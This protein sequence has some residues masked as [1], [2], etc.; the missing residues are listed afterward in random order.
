MTS[1]V[2]S[3]PGHDQTTSRVPWYLARAVYQHLSSLNK[4]VGHCP[5]TLRELYQAVHITFHTHFFDTAVYE[6][7]TMVSQFLSSPVSATNRLPQGVQVKPRSARCHF[8]LTIPFARKSEP[9]LFERILKTILFFYLL[10]FALL[11]FRIQVHVRPV[12][13]DLK[14]DQSSGCPFNP[15]KSKSRH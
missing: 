3:Q 6:S 7:A 4:M 5:D 2:H 8:S 15:S 9:R 1:E 11:E 12:I 10:N 13:R 14:P